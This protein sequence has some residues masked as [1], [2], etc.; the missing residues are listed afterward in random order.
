MQP[1]L[2]IYIDE[3]GDPGV[4]DGVRYAVGRHEWLCLSAVAIRSSR[5]EELPDW[6]REMRV[7]A[8]STQ[9]GALHY[10][11]INAARRKA[12]CE[13]LA[14]KPARAFVLASHKSNMREYVNDRIGSMLESGTFYNW[15]IRLLLERVT[16][17]AETWMKAEL[18]QLE[19]MAVAFAQRGHDYDHF[20]SY[21]D[22]LKM[23][24]EAG[25]LYLKGPGLAPT[26]LDRSHWSV[27]PASSLAGLQL[28]DTMASAFYQA[29]N[30]AS[31]TWDTGPAQALSPII[32]SKRSVVA[33]HGVTVFPLPHQAELPEEARAIFR[34]YGYKF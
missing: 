25:T 6:V 20:N 19:P 29:A 1:T 16:D 24:K 8:N 31:P 11:R 15:C 7:S 30:T 12:V 17:W 18:G 33:N 13:V 5:S 14:A 28:A 3:A 23:Q 10:H 2:S 26:L 27:G 32:V 9:A 34:F 21:V 4:R 22:L